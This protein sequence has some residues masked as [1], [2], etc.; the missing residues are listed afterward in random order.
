MAS[1]EVGDDVYGE[2]PT[3]RLLE[4]ET[5]ARLGKAAALFLPTGTMANQVAVLVH[6]QPGDELWTHEGTHLVSS[7]QGG[8]SRL[9]GVLLRT[10]AA[11]HGELRISQ[12]SPWLHDARDVHY[13][14]PR[15]LW[16]ENS[17]GANGRV[18][19]P[20]RM[21]G[22]SSFAHNHGLFVHLDGSRLWNA[23]V[24]SGLPAAELASDSDSVSVCFSKGLGAPV[25][26]ALAGNEDFIAA[27]RRARKLLGGG[28]RQAGIV[29][30]GALYAL[31][32]NC[33]RLSED[34]RRARQLAD[35]LAVL[36]W[37]RV[38]VEDVQTNIVFTHLK[39]GR[40]PAVAS[41]LREQAVLCDVAGPSLLRFVTHLDIGD[42]ELDQALDV[43]GTVRE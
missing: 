24:A 14:R 41:K 11:R 6:T 22:L 29:A 33:E 1:A 40:A 42:A 27:A 30:A 15:L 32:N 2:D 20:A 34:H 26:S 36:S 5:A 19:P 18:L 21:R 7:E 31:R 23:A 37:C 13:T 4:D 3:V 8:A 43:L 39:L 10:F 17:I 28:M 35:G 16:L 38:D 9:S 25:G 12:L